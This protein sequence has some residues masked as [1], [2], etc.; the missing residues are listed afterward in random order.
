MTHDTIPHPPCTILDILEAR[1][2]ECLFKYLYMVYY[3]AFLASIFPRDAQKPEFPYLG[4][5][6]SCLVSL[7]LNIWKQ[8]LVFEF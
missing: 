4:L 1:F 7:N 8:Y 5:C 6:I 3:A 2:L